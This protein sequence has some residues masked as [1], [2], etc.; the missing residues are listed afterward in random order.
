MSR[1]SALHQLVSS[2]SSLAGFGMS[3]ALALVL[4][5]VSSESSAASAQAPA[6]GGSAP[7]DAVEALGS[8]APDEPQSSP[9][10]R[11]AGAS[12]R[13]FRPSL[14]MGVDQVLVE[15]GATPD[16]PLAS[17]TAWL[18]A[19]PYLQWQ[20]VRNLELRASARLD[21][22]R[23]TG[24]QSYDELRVRFGE[25]GLRWRDGD[26]RLSAGLQTVLW[27][28]VDAVPVID[29][30][31][32]A[33]I[34]RVL[35]DDLQNRRQPQATLR[36]EQAFGDWAADAVVLPAFQGAELPDPRSVWSPLNRASGRVL[37]IP[38]QPLLQSLV[39]G[40]TVSQ[41]DG[42]YAGAALRV[43]HTGDPLDVG[44][45]V[46]RTRQSL[47]YFRP[48][49]VRGTLTAVHPFVE[50]VGVDAEW[51]GIGATWRTELVASKGAPVTSTL[52]Q[53]VLAR[54]TE[55]VGAVEFF[56]G[57]RETRVSLQLLARRL[58]A[59]VPVLEL[60][61]YV[62]LNGEVVTS[63]AQSKWKAG[64]R[65]ASGL[66]VHDTYVGPYLTYA[67]WEPQEIT[68]SAHAFRGN[69]LTLGGFYRDNTYVSLSLRTRF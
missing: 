4:G 40:G 22:S 38:S 34:S 61:R 68:L 66:S 44:L 35:L 18:R 17:G 12:V 54:A 64:L 23:Q 31:S 55:W 69:E 57:G 49:F 27:G 30:V 19:T 11:R 33:D 7:P 2:S 20:P 15:I 5:M 39:Q 59:D 60:T 42:G 45:V 28:R 25:T 8:D 6:Q 43:T 24:S 58:H 29:R 9:S 67:G 63:F 48:D 16:H 51:V 62:G 14:R 26:T 46:G 10:P 41:E 32:R 50:F 1:P 56:P 47:P 3:L 13:A 53:G 52:G 21:A 36:W 37:G 65:F